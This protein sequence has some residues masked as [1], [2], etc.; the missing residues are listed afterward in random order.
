M[1]IENTHVQLSCNSFEVDDFV[2]HWETTELS[3]VLRPSQ[4]EINEYIYDEAIN[5]LAEI[6]GKDCERPA[7]SCVSMTG[8]NPRVLYHGGGIPIQLHGVRTF[9]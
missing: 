4:R 3:E 9:K 8:A 2:D 6:A 1:H 7:E 5:E